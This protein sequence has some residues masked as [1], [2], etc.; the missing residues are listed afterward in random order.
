MGP[1]DGEIESQGALA[2]RLAAVG[3]VLPGS[4]IVRSVRCGK[5]NCRCRAEEPQLHGPYFQWTRTTSTGT[6]TRHLTAELAE[7][8]RSWFDNAAQLRR[9]VDQ[10]QALSASIFERDLSDE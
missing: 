10:L 3:F 5:A 2:Q 8:Y 1:T 6:P 4:L 9:T 7:R